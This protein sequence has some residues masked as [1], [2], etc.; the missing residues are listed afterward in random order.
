MRQV[1]IKKY[2]SEYQ[3]L[4]IGGK[5]YIH[6]GPDRTYYEIKMGFKNQ[7]RRKRVKY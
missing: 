4:Y 1:N 7:F 6:F 5:N 3:D 2:L